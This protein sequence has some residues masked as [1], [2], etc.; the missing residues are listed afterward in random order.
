M[1]ILVT[2]AT[3]FLG[4]SLC[5]R[6]KLDGHVLTGINSGNADLTRAESLNPFDDRTYDQIYHLAA[7]T[8]AGDFCLN[9]PGEQWVINQRINTNV[10][11]WWQKRQPQAKLICMG[12]SC[13]YAP[14][15]ELVEE[16]YLLGT[17]IESL[18][19][20]AMTKK[21]MYVGLLALQRQ[22]GLKYLCLVPST[23]Y[24]P[25]YHT[26]GRQMHFIFDLIR[27]IMRGKLHGEPVVLWGNGYQ[28][29]E[30]VYVDDFVSI[31]LQL[32]DKSENDLINVGAGEEFTIRHFAKMICEVVGYDFEKIQ[33]DHTRYVGAMS[34]CLCAAKMRRLLPGLTLT[35]LESGMRKTIEWFSEEAPRLLGKES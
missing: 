28:K 24:G 15:E 1:N 25:S 35:P 29:R 34:K 8:Q 16:N 10:L 19:T 18:F 6:L 9:H 2:G 11:A 23:L 31:M 21:M 33:F 4:T 26:D 12:T 7:W 3:G 22:Y 17:P 20:Y 27:K 14:D 13:A 30:L 5:A 32:V